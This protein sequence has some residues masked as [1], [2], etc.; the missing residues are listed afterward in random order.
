[1]T[2]V[3]RVNRTATNVYEQRDTDRMMCLSSWRY[4][5]VGDNWDIARLTRIQSNAKGHN[6][7]FRWSSMCALASSISHSK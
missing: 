7:G 6:V 3:E 1:L 4:G 5:A 2:T